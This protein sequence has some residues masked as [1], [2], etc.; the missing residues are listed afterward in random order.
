MLK[1][2]PSQSGDGM[3]LGSDIVECLRI[4][5][6]IENHGERFLHQVYTCRETRF[7]NERK[8]PLEHFAALWAAKE[9]ILKALGLAGRGLNWTD[10]EVCQEAEGRPEVHLSGAVRDA[11]QRQGVGGVLLSLAHCRAYATAHV[12]VLRGMPAAP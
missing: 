10:I 6:M 7:C 8:R 3:G 9:A 5:R 4:G 11:A 2:A 1:V 12:L